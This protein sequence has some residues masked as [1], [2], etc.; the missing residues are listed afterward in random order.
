MTSVFLKGYSGCAVED[1]GDGG[2]QEAKTQEELQSVADQKLQAAQR[3]R[4]SA[5]NKAGISE[6]LRAEKPR[7]TPTHHRTV[8]EAN[9][10][11]LASG[12]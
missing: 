12:G 10:E 6:A 7:P 9:T 1:V 8:R 3:H 4:G 5:R 2:G 11:A